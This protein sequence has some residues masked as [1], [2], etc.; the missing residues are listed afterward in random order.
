MRISDWSSDVCSSDLKGIEL[1]FNGSILPGW[2]IFG[3]YTYLD[4]KIT[5]GGFTSLAVAANGAA[6]ATTVLVPSVNTGRPFPQTAKHSFT[7]WTDSH[8]TPDIS[9]GGG[10]FYMTRAYGGFQDTR[11]PNKDR[12]EARRVGKEG[13]SPGRSRGSRDHKKKRQK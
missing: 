12:S 2:S 7:V 9:I 6:P 8:V 4:A 5:D 11:T 13:V 1:G 10:A 3:G